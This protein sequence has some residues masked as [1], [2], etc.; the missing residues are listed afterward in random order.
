MLET[1]ECCRYVGGHRN[2]KS[3]GI[4]IPGKGESDVVCPRPINGNRVKLAK[5]VEEVLCIFFIGIF[6]TKIV[7]TQG[8]RN[9]VVF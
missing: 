6:Y 5:C 1:C 4:I 8:E 2:F 9:I 3:S 7:N